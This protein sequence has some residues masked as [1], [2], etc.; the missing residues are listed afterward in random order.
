MATKPHPFVHTE[1]TQWADFLS[2][3]LSEEFQ[4]V[5]FYFAWYIFFFHLESCCLLFKAIK[6]P[7]RSQYLQNE[8]GGIRSPLYS[9][10]RFI[11]LLQ[12]HPSLIPSRQILSLTSQM[13]VFNSP[14][15]IC[16]SLQCLQTD[17]ML[18]AWMFAHRVAWSG[19]WH[20]CT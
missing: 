16:M 18:K 11:N 1:K 10:I 20:H 4:W 19:G 3:S 8:I 7:L 12:S 2:F 13:N 14:A 17:C 5:H 15:P 9:F 6:Y